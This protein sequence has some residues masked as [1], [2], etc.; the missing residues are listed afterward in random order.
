MTTDPPPVDPRRDDGP[1]SRRWP[2][3]VLV[4][5]AVLLAGYVLLR[6]AGVLGQPGDVGGGGVLLVGLAMT[7]LGAGV[8]LS[9][10]LDGRR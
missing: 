7:V 9:D 1:V 5:G 3:A 8:T 4:T 2:R 10:R 6:A